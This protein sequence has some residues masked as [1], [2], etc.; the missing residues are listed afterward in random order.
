M[1][2]EIKWKVNNLPKGDKENCIKFLNEEEITKVRNFHK[3]FPQYKETPLANLEGLAKKL[4]V[5]GVY[6]KDESYRFG[7][8][9]FKVLGGSYSMGKYLA[10][11][12]DTDISELGYD[13]LT[14][15]E[16]KEK[17]GEITFFTA[18]DGNHG[19]GVAWTANKLG[20]KSVVLMPKGS[21]E[22]R[23]NKI[24]GEGAE[25]SI[26]DLNYDDA[27]RLANDYAE[28]DDHGVMVQDTAWDGY[29]EIPA[30]IMQGYGTMAQEAIEQL[31]EY[32]VDR[33]T[34]V[35]VQAGVGSLAG[36]VQGYVASI[37]DECPITVVVEADEAD[38][39]YKSAEAGDGKPRFVGGDMPTIM[40]GLAC[41]EPNTIGFEVLKDHAAAFV[42]APD[43]VS[44]KGMRT[45][46][47][48]LNG[49][50]K[51]ISGES[52]AVTTGLLVAAMERED[53]ADLRKDLKLDENSRILLISTEGDTDPDKY[54]S[55]VWDGEYPS[56]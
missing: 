29:E 23:L 33:P 17:L 51:V 34:H 2:K 31:K 54:R 40:A 4:G 32:G 55:I 37:Y 21:S 53:L 14:S 10:Q 26:T 42:S 27:V 6:V 7:L 30:W 56:I 49:D 5:A 45:L 22:F 15:D 52:G 43:W 35:F 41:G 9:A 36:A 50:E 28:A 48:P 8:N 18:T 20:Q 3:S 39:Y 47:N 16:I 44:A 11:R 24:K 38:C 13:K 25:A 1:L 19:R 12:L 46:G